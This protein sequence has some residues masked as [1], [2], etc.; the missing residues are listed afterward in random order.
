MLKFY[1]DLASPPVRAVYFTIK[2]LN[3]PVEMINVKLFQGECRS[4][5]YLKVHTE[6]YYIILSKYYLVPFL[7]DFCPNFEL[8][9][10]I[11]PLGRLPLIDD[12]GIILT[13]RL[14]HF[15]S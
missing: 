7:L 11:N 6:L 13:D 3:V 2:H 9:F 5:D 1:Y 12:G 4:K 15:S 10:Q 14:L 8:M